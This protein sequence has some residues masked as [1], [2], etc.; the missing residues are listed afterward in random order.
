MQEFINSPLFGWV[1]VPILIC[2]GRII[3]VSLGTL[4]IIFV[5]RGMKLF[6]AALGFFEVLIWLVAIGQ[7]MKNLTHF[8]NY[9]A[10]ATGFAIG[11]YLGIILEEKLAIGK[12]TVRIITNHDASALIAFLREKNFLVTVVDAQ[13]STGAVNI[14]FTAIWRSQ[15]PLVK[16]Y[17]LRFNPQAFY[18]V[19]DIR[20]VSGGDFFDPAIRWRAKRGRGARKLK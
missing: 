7:I 14:L 17:I 4:R 12:I 19:E 16:E 9:F 11:N 10:Y 18:T 20:V 6:A 2:I 15:L 8:G 5:S 1:V 3:D 13:G